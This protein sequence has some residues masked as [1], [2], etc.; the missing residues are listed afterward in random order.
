LKL[1]IY[2]NGNFLK[3][4]RKKIIESDLSNYIDIKGMVIVDKIAEA[5]KQ[6]DLGV[7]PNRINPFTQ[8]NFPVRTF[9][10]IVMNKPV[11]VPRTQGIS[12]YFDEESIFFFEPGNVESLASAIMEIYEH[13]KKKELVLRKS[14][15]VFNNYRWESQK[16]NLIELTNKL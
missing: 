6:I 7:I 11:V 4:I 10:Y 3:T 5:I 1:W 14:I 9:E 8:I 15:D 12:D 16:Q 2:G 13:P